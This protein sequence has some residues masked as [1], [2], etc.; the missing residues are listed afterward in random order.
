MMISVT[1][2]VIA[3]LRIYTINGRSW[4]L[5]GL[6]ILLGLVP[7]ATNLVCHANKCRYQRALTKSLMQLDAALWK[8]ETVPGMEGCTLVGGWSAA[9]SRMYVYTP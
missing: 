8:V 4:R 9:T 3:G 6:V 7:A 2:L 1:L 5:P